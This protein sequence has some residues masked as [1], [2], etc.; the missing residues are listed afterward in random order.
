MKNLN[1]RNLK[2][3]KNYLFLIS[4]I[5]ILLSALA[6]ILIGAVNYDSSFEIEKKTLTP[7]IHA[8]FKHAGTIFYFTYL[9]NIF[10]GVTLVLLSLSTNKEKILKMFVISVSLIT[11]TFIVYWTLLS[12]KLETWSSFFRA[13]RSTITHAINPIIAFIAL[14]L[15][16]K[17]VS[18]SI[19]EIKITTFIAIGYYIFALIVFLATYNIIAKNNGVVIYSFLDF[20]K[21]LFYRGGVLGIIVL[22][23][24]LILVLVVGI[25]LGTLFFWKA[26]YKIKF[27]KPTKC[28]KNYWH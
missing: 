20:A 9:T 6:F 1:L 27:I 13:I 26:V 15:L 7:T 5:F 28:S 11:I 17:K 21:P 22:L 10:T 3:N 19:K 18:I 23:D 2:Q 14:F 4:G 8:L 16:R 24:V 12:Y 25:S